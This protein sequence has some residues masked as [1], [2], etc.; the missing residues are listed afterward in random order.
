[1]KSFDEFKE[2][3]GAAGGQPEVDQMTRLHKLCYDGGVYEG[4]AEGRRL[5][6]EETKCASCKYWRQ[7][8]SPE[9]KGDCEGW[10]NRPTHY[11]DGC[12][13][14]ERRKE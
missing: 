13:H 3:L 4:I 11:D 9:T 6:I 5:Q 14:H 2:E 12:I 7:F 10:V 8:F 1:M